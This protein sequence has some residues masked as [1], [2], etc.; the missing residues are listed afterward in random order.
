MIAKVC[1]ALLAAGFLAGTSGCG[2]MTPTA[3]LPGAVYAAQ[4]PVYPSSTADGMMGGSY[5]GSI[6]GPDVSQTQSWFFNT[7]DPMEDVVAFY[8]EKLA[9]ATKTEEEQE[10]GE[11]EVTFTLVPPDAEEGEELTVR[12]TPGRIQITEEVLP[13]KIKDDD[14]F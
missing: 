4:V 9:G 7:D 5:R 13:G 8:D 1:I 10:E 12:V 11:E 14:P 6:G 2:A 3:K